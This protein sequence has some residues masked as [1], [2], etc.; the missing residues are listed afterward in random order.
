MVNSTHGRPRGKI[1]VSYP[2]RGNNAAS[3]ARPLTTKRAPAVKGKRR[4]WP[5][6]G[7]RGERKP[8]SPVAAVWP[9]RY[10]DGPGD[11]THLPTLLT[12]TAQ[13][14]ENLFGTGQRIQHDG[15]MPDA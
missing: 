5:N 6:S 9:G 2:Q 11:F 8:V 13:V 3:F 12:T 15:G 4:V 10:R 14:D 7:K 1:G